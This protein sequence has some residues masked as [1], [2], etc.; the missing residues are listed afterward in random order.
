MKTFAKRFLW[1]AFSGFIIL[2]AAA[3]CTEQEPAGKAA[4]TYEGTVLDGA[5][6]DF[7]LTD[8]NGHLVNL[9]DFRGQ[10]VALTFMDSQCQ[11]TCPVTASHFITAHEALGAETDDVVFLGVNVNVN[12]SEVADVAA[13]TRKWRLD[14]ISSFHF[15]T[16]SAVELGAVWRGYGVG[17]APTADA[18][19]H[20]PG[21]Y[22]ID[23]DGQLRRYISTSFDETGVVQGT[24]PLSELLV[25]QIRALLREG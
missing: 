16:G 17:V 14:K 21:V 9:S 20:T 15:L 18:V 13:T 4:D 24:P 19:Q 2:L 1:T 12:A 3:A 7:Q 5:A 25:K 6:P 8:Q 23:Q 11:D 22:L 10:V